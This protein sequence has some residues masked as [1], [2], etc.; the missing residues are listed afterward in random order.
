M[1]GYPFVP[2]STADLTLG[3]LWSVRLAGGDLAVLQVRGLKT[4]GAGAY[5]HFVAGVVDWRAPTLPVGHDLRG[6][7]VLAEGVVR[8]EVFGADRAQV[9]GSNLAV[10]PP[11]AW[12]E[13][14]KEFTAGTSTEVWSWKS[15]RRRVDR[16]LAAAAA[17]RATQPD[18]PAQPA[19]PAEPEGAD[20]LTP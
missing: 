18:Q 17:D 5:T 16:V 2:S 15:V 19:E 11:P 12:S 9:F 8:F 10:V 6:R 3:D 14:A 7:R 13:L 1:P 20:P 4:S